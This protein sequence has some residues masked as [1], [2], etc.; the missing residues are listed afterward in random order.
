MAQAPLTGV[1]QFRRQVDTI[2]ADSAFRPVVTTMK[3]V[4]LKTS[5]VLYERNSQVLMRPASNLK[6]ITSATALVR[7]GSGFK[8]TTRLSYDGTITD[9]VL[10]GNIYFK[11]AGDPDL[12]TASIA[13][14]VREVRSRGIARIEGDIIG[15]A[16]YFDGE[17]WGVGWMWDD[18]PSLDEAYNSALSVNR[19]CVQV[20]AAPGD[21]AGAAPVV[22]VIPATQYMTEENTAV[23]GAPDSDNTLEISRKYRE[24]TNIITVK[25]SIPLGARRKREDISVLGPEQYFLTLAKEELQRLHIT[26]AGT[27]RLGTLP[28][29]ARQ[30]AVH[31]QPID[32]MVI[33]QNKVSDNLSAEN[34]LKAV[35][36]EVLGGAGS[37]EHG[38]SLVKQTLAEFGIDSS[39]FRM[40]DGSGVSHYN[41]LT[42]EI[43]IKLLQAMAKKKDLFDIYYAS[44][45]IAGV[46]GTLSSRMKNTPAQYNLHAKTGTLSGVTT[47]AGYVTTAEGEMLAFS[48]MMSSFIGTSE[49][50]RRAQDAIGVLMANFKR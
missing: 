36:A 13:S 24:C 46:D 28:A 1:E 15:D 44:L 7:L 3:I 35:S 34:S 48:M 12:T 30:I 10:H 50:Y 37:S 27:T 47:L 14:L 29:A 18:E 45:P 21:S 23:T 4:S 32:S 11:G 6:L 25:G 19:N 17:R 22:T 41:L 38:I 20:L 9:S 16:T 5:D 39:A 33:F 31:E 40:V 49:P 8:F 26:V 43:Y 42:S 2:L